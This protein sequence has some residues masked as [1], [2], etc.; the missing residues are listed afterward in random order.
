MLTSIRG[1]RRFVVSLEMMMRTVTV[2]VNP[3]WIDTLEPLPPR[4]HLGS[5]CRILTAERAYSSG[6]AHN[7]NETLSRRLA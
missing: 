3:E 6:T 5:S 4:P 1:Q 2:E 7:W